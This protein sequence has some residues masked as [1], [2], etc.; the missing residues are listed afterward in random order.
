MNSKISQRGTENKMLILK[1][2]Y[3]Q[4]MIKGFKSDI[5]FWQKDTLVEILGWIGHFCAS[6]FQVWICRKSDQIIATLNITPRWSPTKANVQQGPRNLN[7]PRGSIAIPDLS[8]NR[9]L[10]FQFKRP[11]ITTRPP[12]FSNFPVPLT[13][14]SSTEEFFRL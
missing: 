4:V 5:R 7:G 6:I 14:K 10:T 13:V 1:K 2:L 11:W 12:G 9:S 8:R 3:F